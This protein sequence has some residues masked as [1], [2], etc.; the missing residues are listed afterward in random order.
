MPSSSAVQRENLWTWA[1][2]FAASIIILAAAP[3]QYLGRQQDD[4]MYALAA[5]SLAYGQGFRLITSPGLPWMNVVS[6]G[7]PVLLFPLAYFFPG[8]FGLFELACAFILS[9]SPWVFWL[10][11]KKRKISFPEDIL[12]VLVFATSPLIL[13]QSGTVMSESLFVF[14]TLIFLLF[15]ESGVSSVR[16]WGGGLSLLAIIQTRLAGISLLFAA[17]FRP[18]RERKGKELLGVLALTLTPL[19]IWTYYSLHFSGQIQKVKEGLD[20]YGAAP[21]SILLVA[22]KNILYYAD[23]LGSCFL[24]PKW[25]GG[26][27]GILIGGILGGVAL[28]G[29]SAWFKKE[30]A[31]P[32]F[33]ALAA[34]LILHLFWPWHYDRYL[35]MPLPLI[36]LAFHDGIKRFAVP[37]LVVLLAAQAAFSLPQWLSASGG[38]NRVELR[39]SYAWL[40]SNS[41]PQDILASALYVRDGFYAARPSVPL[42]SKPNAK[43]LNGFF[44]AH[45]VRY[46]LWV[47]NLDL[48]LSDAGQSPVHSTLQRIYGE[49]K[50]AQFFKL[51]YENG[52]EDSAIYRV[53]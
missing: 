22:F 32:A 24:P 27:A 48:G 52:R 42:A 41:K 8:R 34:T 40:R 14:L 33:W 31:S 26:N 39:E 38:F 19:L 51:V 2:L 1:A 7:L 18:L 3:A 37:V 5:Q 50:D 28:S 53:R 49:L 36:L 15:T 45:Q 47:G 6:P 9:L 4:L 44:K 46:I 21:G 12:L 10:W 11:L 20:F 17:L 25:A 30:R 16:T 13:S 43:A 35:M 29:M 23:S